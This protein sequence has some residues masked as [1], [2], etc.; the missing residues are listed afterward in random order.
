MESFQE[1]QKS[2]QKTLM[3]FGY[4]K[5]KQ[6]L[7]DFKEKARQMIIKLNNKKTAP[8]A[9]DKPKSYFLS[10]QKNTK[11]KTNNKTSLAD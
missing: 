9:R 2:R 4:A 10:N 7:E 11:T 3:N 6:E 8:F 5:N 1:N